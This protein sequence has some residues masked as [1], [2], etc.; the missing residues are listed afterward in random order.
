MLF[1]VSELVYLY[2]GNMW[3]SYWM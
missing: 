1:N 3:C 2:L